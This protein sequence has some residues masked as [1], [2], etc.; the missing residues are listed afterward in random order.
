MSSRERPIE[1]PTARVL[2]LDGDGRTLLFRARS[3]DG[4]GRQLWFAP[5]GGLEA[6][7]SW[8]A[9]ARRELHE[10]TGL[11]VELGPCIWTRAHTWH[12]AERDQ[13]I[14]SVERYFVAR[15]DVAEIVR[16]RWTELERATIAEHRWWSAAAMRDS[17]DIFVPRSLPELLPGLVAGEL[18]REPFDVG[19]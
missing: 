5:G 15:T 4:S 6:G 14:R 8:E 19:V 17:H 18:P 10:E 2:V 16:D 13:W 1:R 11:T 12:F 9:A 3:V 7:E